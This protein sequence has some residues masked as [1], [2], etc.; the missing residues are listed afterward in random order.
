MSC[1]ALR[2]CPQVGTL[3]TAGFLDV[4]SLVRR[5]AKDAGK[6]T[7]T[8]LIGKPSPAKMAN[9]PEVSRMGVVL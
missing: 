3:A 4:V 7:Y 5:L 2:V 8:V 6:K 1:F 9:F